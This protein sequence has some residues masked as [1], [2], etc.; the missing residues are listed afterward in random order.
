MPLKNMKITRI[1]FV[2]NSFV[3]QHYSLQENGGIVVNSK[4]VW[5]LAISIKSCGKL[6]DPS[7]GESELKLMVET[8][9]FK[10]SVNDNC[11]TLD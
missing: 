7:F 3:N 6:I 1:P 9:L 8:I 10:C 4:K 11:A 5:H 2:S